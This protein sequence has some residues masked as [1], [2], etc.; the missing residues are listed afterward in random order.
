MLNRLSIKLFFTIFVVN[1]LISGVIYLSVAHSIDRGFV[2]YVKR[3]QRHQINNIVETLQ[4]HWEEEQGW[5]W[6]DQKNAWTNVLRDSVGGQDGVLFDISTPPSSS[7]PLTPP[8]SDP[9]QFVL[10]G[11]D[12]VR[13]QGRPHPPSDLKR[14]PIIVDGQVVGELGYPDS[15]RFSHTLDRIFLDNQ[16]D[17]LA[18]ILLALLPASLLLAAGIA[19]WLGRRARLM[20]SAAQSLTLGDYRVRLPTQGQDELSRF[21]TDINTLARTLEQNRAAR[22]RWGA[23]IAHELRTP[24]AILRGEL[25][26]MQDGVRP[27]NA[28]NL[29]SLSLEVETLSRLVND[30]RLLAE[31]DNHRL[32][33]Q[34]EPLDLS[35]LLCH[36]LEDRRQTVSNR[37]FTLEL[38]IEPDVII[39]GAP[40]RLRQL[41]RNLLENTLAYTDAPGTIRIRLETTDRYAVVS[42][43]DSPPGVP[44]EYLGRLTERLFRVDASR[45]RTSGGS[46]LGLSIVQALVNLHHG[47][48]QAKSSALGGLCWVIYLPLAASD[49]N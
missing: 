2:N 42:W 1:V 33:A 43:E 12:G 27:I 8:L 24:L 23:D 5:D 30:L 20:A 29:G 6:L 13:L 38:D 35:D 19:L 40:Y 41:W 7:N 10:Y 48:M 39:E 11:A 22:Q 31:T 9:R 46:G 44:N 14:V 18:I 17:S 49:S 37:G 45:N 16:L 15:S 21:S 34:L 4:S 25:E 47:N 32:D 26:A 28:H 36:Q 3:G